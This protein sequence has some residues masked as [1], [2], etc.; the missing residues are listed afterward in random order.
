[1]SSSSSIEVVTAVESINVL[2]KG[3]R[4]FGV[5]NVRIDGERVLLLMTSSIAQ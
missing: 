2:R 1:M 5:V 4:W 3:Y